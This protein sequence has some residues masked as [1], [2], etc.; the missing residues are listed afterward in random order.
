MKIFKYIWIVLFTATL[1]SCES[2]EDTYSEFAGDGK[3]RYVAMCEDVEVTPGWQR[4]F[5]TWKNATDA[6]ISKVRVTWND[7]DTTMVKDLPKETDS[8]IIENLDDIMYEVNVHS[9]NEK[10]ELSLIEKQNFQR[11]YT[12][13]HVD[14]VS[15]SPIISKHFVVDN[16]RLVLFFDDWDSRIQNAHLSYYEEGS[17]IATKLPLNE[18]MI[19]A[20]NKMLLLPEKIDATKQISVVRNGKLDGCEDDITFPDFILTDARVFSPEFLTLMLAKYGVSTI[21]NEFING[22]DALDIDYFIS[23]FEDILYFP[24]LQ[25]VKL[26]ANRFMV[27]ATSEQMASY[28]SNLGSNSS[29]EQAKAKFVFDI[30]NQILGVT[31]D[32]YNDHYKVSEWAIGAAYF[33]IKGNT[34]SPITEYLHDNKSEWTIG[35]KDESDVSF[36]A[37][38]K[39]LIDGISDN[40]GTGYWLTSPQNSKVRTHSFVIDMKE[41]KMV[42]GIEIKQLLFDHANQTTKKAMPSIVQILV[43]T[44]N[45]RFA[46]ATHVEDNILGQS[47]NEGTIFYL[48]KQKAVRYIK[49]IVE[50][51]LVDFNYQTG[52]AEVNV[53]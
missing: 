42:T 12:M 5:V 46:N 8:Y 17:S 10:G 47:P 53:F 4:L 1:F 2:I 38:P 41:E 25:K 26:G 52:L 35:P 13:T 15:F 21:T 30:A 16:N 18:A 29:E 24:N 20:N 3:I 19:A 45:V 48:S 9:V 40:A 23:S 37:D 51:Q 39:F 28:L 27:N 34:S 31:V 36:Y 49:I 22:I 50:D 7:G 44:D 11:P 14:V 32:S 6:T 43:S 33:N